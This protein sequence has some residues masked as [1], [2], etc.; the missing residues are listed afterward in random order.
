MRDSKDK[1]GPA[2]LFPADTFTAFVTAVRAG[3]F[4]S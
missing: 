4:K 2:L 3:H 1:T